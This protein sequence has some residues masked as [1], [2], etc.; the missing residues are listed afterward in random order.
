M[1]LS[2]LMLLLSSRQ[3]ELFHEYLVL[4]GVNH[5]GVLPI[6]QGGVIGDG[7][8]ILI[9][10]CCIT[11]FVDVHL[12]QETLMNSVCSDQTCADFVYLFT[13]LINWFCS[14]H[15]NVVTINTTTKLLI[16]E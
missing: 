1:W 14:G 6:G 15:L 13:M 4:C 9:L 12:Q 2:L 7:T 16:N 3:L 5:S 8:T 11:V 10:C